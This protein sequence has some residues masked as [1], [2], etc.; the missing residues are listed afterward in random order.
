MANSATR[1]QRTAPSALGQR[2][3]D[4][5]HERTD[6]SYPRWVQESQ[7]TGQCDTGRSWW[8]GSG[9]HC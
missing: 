2:I 5:W 6:R 3:N 8:S 9:W 7:A 4:W 1:S